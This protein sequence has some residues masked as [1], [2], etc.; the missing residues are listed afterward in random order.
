[1]SETTFLLSAV[2]LTSYLLADFV[3]KPAIASRKM[4]NWQP[5]ILGGVLMAGLV[6]LLLGVW[7]N[8]T[9]PLLAFLLF[10]VIESIRRRSKKSTL[11]KFILW[12]VAWLVIIILLSLWY[13]SSLLEGSWWIGQLG[14]GYV[15]ALIVLA[16]F[17]F[18]I[19][20]G[21]QLI[22]LA[23]QPLQDEM[24]KANKN[25]NI[26]TGLRKGGKWIGMLERALIYV[27]VLGSQYAAIGFLVAAKSILRF[28]EVKESSNRMDA[29]Y[30]IIGTLASFLF[31][32]L[33]GLAADGLLKLI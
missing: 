28:G 13:P 5:P 1:M 33:S 6:Y 7:A 8:F 26:P 20:P 16:G 27:F 32:L 25:R 24:Q 2:L 19:F 29:E 31:A 15:K 10:A 4:K 11:S 21:S 18:S 9:L 17:I 22:G 3:F 30:I 14:T 23:L 12:L